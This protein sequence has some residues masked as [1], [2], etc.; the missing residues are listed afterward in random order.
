MKNL[1]TLISAGILLSLMSLQAQTTCAGDRV[2]YVDSKN[3][4]VTGSYTLTI[5]AE[6]MA[7]QTYHYSGPGEV[8]GARVYGTV[9]SGLGVAV[10]VS[11]YNVDANG[12]PSGAALA[13][14]PLRNVYSWSPAYFNVSFSPAVSVNS[15][16]ALVV[17]IVDLPGRGHN[18]LLRYTGNGEGLG[19]DLA[20][21]AGSSTG[22]N[23]ASAMSA[24]GKDGDFYIYP[25][26]INFNT[27]GFS[28]LS[29]CIDTGVPIDFTNTTAMTLDRMFNTIT[30]PGY[31]GSNFLYTWNFGDGSS[32]SHEV[33]PFHSYATAGIYTVEL[34][35]LI[36]GWDSDCSQTFSK[37]ISVGLSASATSITNVNCNGGNDGNMAALGTGGGTPYIYSLNGGNYQSNANFTGLTAGLYTL[38]IQDVVG[39][40]RTTSFIIHQPLPI[41]FTSTSSTNATCGNPDGGIL[42]TS[43]GGVSPI[44]YQ[45][46]SG[47]FQPNGSFNNL[48]AGG[49]NIT[50]KDAN[51]CT[52]FIHVVINDVGGPQFTSVNFT[53][54]SCFGGNDASITLSSAGGTGNIQYSING[55]LTFQ[56][57]G[58]FSNVTAGTYITIVKDAAGCTDVQII[59]V[60]QPQP[61]TITVSTV[62]LTCFESN[63]GQINITST[64][65]GTGAAS[66]SINGVVFQSGTNFPGLAAGTYTVY[67]RD[68][69][70]CVNS[71]P[72]NVTQPTL[73][74]SSV[75]VSNAT[76]NGYEDGAITIAGSGGTPAYTYGIGATP[77]Y[78]SNGTFIELAAGTYPLFVS[79]ENGCTIQTNVT[80]NEPTPVV[81]VA[82][83]TNSTCGNSNGGIL[84]VSTGGSGT[85]YTYSLDGGTFGVGSFSSLAAGI[86]VITAM[87]GTGCSSVTN[88][89]V[90][91]SNGPTIL[92]SSS[93]NVNCHGGN[94]GSITV[95]AVTGGTGTLYYSI[96][97]ITYQTSPVFNNLPAGVYDV[98][99]KDAVGCIGNT[100][101]TITEPNAFLIT[102]NV[103]NA[104]CYGSSTGSVTLLVGGGSGTLAFSINGESTFQSSNVFTNLA[105]GIYQVAVRDA[106]GCVGYASVTI[107]QPPML[108]AT[109]GSLNV[110][111]AGAHNGTLNIFAW[112]GSGALEFSLNGTTYQLSNIF[113]GLAGGSY[114]AF[115]R[116]ANGCVI[117]IP[118]IVHEPLPLTISENI[119]QVSCAGG[120]NGVID[121][122]ITGGTPYYYF[123]WSNGAI[124]EDNFNLAAGNYSVVVSDGYGCT[125]TMSYTIT[126][127]SNAIIVNGTVT[128]ASGPN[129][130]AINITITGG[131]GG[132]IF[133]WSNGLTTEDVSGLGAGVYTVIVTDGNG[134]AASST[135]V[136]LSTV[137]INNTPDIDKQLSIYPNPVNTEVT[138]S[139]QGF[140]IDKLELFDMLGQIV[141]SV[142]PKNSEVKLNTSS[143]HS[144]VYFLRIMSGDNIISRKID[145][146]K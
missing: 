83:T 143:L 61:L 66:Y 23:W 76:C 31:S 110:T 60:A 35:S 16:F 106:G 3:V 71:I 127:P 12:R 84:I 14:A 120:N 102:M 80:I 138:I 6:E 47:P 98:T 22:S 50:A 10:R 119:S 18:F 65:G 117:V 69:T 75:N 9:P 133:S 132:Y 24:F 101:I 49:Y 62:P 32:V 54:I 21:L 96:N 97:G 93:T 121:L 72:V 140:M 13:V 135:F 99:V 137:G 42:V 144:G 67:A 5:G 11:L 134:C 19:E 63:N 95:G 56:S 41:D 34:T 30:A 36:D 51:N 57:S 55:G 89:T 129:N 78:Q 52:S 100:S 43:S 141:N 81:P 79:D 45:L 104:T 139:L 2:A 131:V 126:Q 8:A 73:L 59:N 53:N 86:Y 77:V 39:C 58:I 145:I 122:S 1:I 7:A 85:G 109:Y 88:V 70:G 142:E 105:A 64:T 4:G 118:A 114:N 20:S 90:F 26:M 37:T 27:P 130:G 146:I 48:T 46:N 91:D 29:S 74:T 15:N 38:F 124:T 136:I 115:V 25:R 125:S 107:T 94:D 87:D 103:T 108:L 82:T 28:V 17:E 111:C 116:D 44:Q 128:N 92:S 68:V 112:G 33:N 123:D 113:S 40:I